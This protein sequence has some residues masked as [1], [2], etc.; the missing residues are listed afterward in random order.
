MIANHQTSQVKEPSCF[1]KFLFF[2]TGFLGFSLV[3]FVL[4]ECY[5]RVR[6]PPLDLLAITGRQPGANP[7]REWAMVDAFC[8]YRGRPGRYEKEV[9]KTINQHGFISTPE[10]TLAK[11]KN[12]IRIAFLGASSTAGT[13][14]NLADQDTWPWQVGQQLQDKLKHIKIE[15]INGALGGYSSFESYGR[16]W[17]RLRFFDL[18]FL[19]L[20]HGWNEMYYFNQVNDMYKWRT[21]ADGSWSLDILDQ[22]MY[23][24]KLIDYVI[25]PSQLL[26]RIRLRLADHRRGQE[27]GKIR[28]HESYDPRALDLWGTN[29]RL[30]RETARVLGVK[31]LVCKQPTL[32]VPDLPPPERERCRYDY[33][34]FDHEAHVTAFAQIY[35]IIEEEIPPENIIDLTAISGHPQ[36]FYDHVHPTEEGAEKIAALV[37]KALLPHI[38]QRIQERRGQP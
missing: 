23:E 37:A 35:R 24:P 32:V 18:D 36:Y 4:A 8:A 34:G 27:A 20:N 1:R 19:V 6:K 21:L 11:P 13:G 17:S 15:F 22:A 28:R 29:L 26:C 30:F 7:M 12:A 14:I 10:M 5:I 33:H 31:L 3:F 2:L 9:K 38:S 25:F 16:F